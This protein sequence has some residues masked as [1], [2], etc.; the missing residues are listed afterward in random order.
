MIART[1]YRK[2]LSDPNNVLYGNI[3]CLIE[4]DLDLDQQETSD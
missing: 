3:F 4:P 2:M 1:K